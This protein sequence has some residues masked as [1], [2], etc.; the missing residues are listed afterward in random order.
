MEL[1]RTLWNETEIGCELSPHESCTFECPL[2]RT[3]HQEY[4]VPFLGLHRLFDAFLVVIGE[5]FDDVAVQLAVDDPHPCESS[6]SELLRQCDVSIHI[7]PSD[8]V[9]CDIFLE[10]HSDDDTTLSDDLLHDAVVGLSEH[11]CELLQW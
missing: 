7:V 3:C 6:E 8:L 2:P 10:I 1:E 9:A 4:E 11:L 5:V